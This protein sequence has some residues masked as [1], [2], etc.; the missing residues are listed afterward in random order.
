[1][2]PVEPRPGTPLYMVARDVIRRA[3]HTGHFRPGEQLPSTAS[4]SSQLSVS[5]V[6]MHRALRELE[7]LGLIDRKQGRGTFVA[8]GTS[9]PSRKLRLGLAIQAG[10]SLADYYHGQ[11]IEGMNQAAREAHAELVIVQYAERV[12]Q[13]CGGHLLLNPI[14]SQAAL[15]ESSRP[16]GQPMLVVGARHDHVPWI[17]VDNFDLIRRAVEHVYSLG[18]RRVGYVGGAPELSNSRDRYAGFRETCRQLGLADFERDVLTAEDWRLAE[19]DKLRV[20]ELIGRGDAPT[21]LIVGGYY[22]A[23][24]VYQVAAARGLS[25]PRDLTVVG[26]DDP[27]SAQHIWP[28]LTTMRQPLAQLGYAAVSGLLGVV[29]GPEAGLQ[30]QVLP[31]ELVVRESSIAVA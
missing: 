21:A 11:I 20:A 29:H 12:P 8:D 17:D 7:G 24:D 26:V 5:L 19:G 6:T 23:L 14:G 30:N 25:I 27:P 31:G 3:I 18:H 22:L 28:P 10:A 16:A 13:G 15:Y 1:M 4:L 2:L 9:P